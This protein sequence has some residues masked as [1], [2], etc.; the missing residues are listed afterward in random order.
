M[1]L[2][3]WEESVELKQDLTSFTCIRIWMNELYL[4]LDSHTLQMP[5]VLSSELS[6]IY[7]SL[8]NGLLIL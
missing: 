3:T 1:F 7:H 8:N 2:E 6:L 5:Y 4:F